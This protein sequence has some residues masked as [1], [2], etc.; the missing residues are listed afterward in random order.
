MSSPESNN[1]WHFL[2]SHTQVLLCIHSDTKARLRDIASTV[3]IT[4]RAAQ[5]I[6]KDLVEAGYVSRKRAGRRNRYRVNAHLPMRHPAQID[7]Q[8]AEL[9]D[10]LHLEEPPGASHIRP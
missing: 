4:E 10:V 2:T 6:V 7:H 9:L 3:G 1:T 8:V 5:R